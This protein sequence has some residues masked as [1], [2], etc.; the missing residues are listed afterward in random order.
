SRHPAKR[1]RNRRALAMGNSTPT[2]PGYR[3]VTRTHWG[4]LIPP[5]VGNNL[6]WFEFLIICFLLTEKKIQFSLNF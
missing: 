3:Q 4:P 1:Q 6:Y 2:I 5:L